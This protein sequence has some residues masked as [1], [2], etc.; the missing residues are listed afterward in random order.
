MPRWIHEATNRRLTGIEA[1]NLH[2]ILR[3][4]DTNG[5]G[6]VNLPLPEAVC[7]QAGLPAD[8]VDAVLEQGD[9]RLWSWDRGNGRVF[10]YSPKRIRREAGMI[11]S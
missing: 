8:T 11:K 9:G 2:C 1:D 4:H 3:A 7:Q 5:R 10:L 6:A